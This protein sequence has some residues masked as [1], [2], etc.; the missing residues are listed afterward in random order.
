MRKIFS[1]AMLILWISPC[2]K[3]FAEEGFPCVQDAQNFSSCEEFRAGWESGENAR[4]MGEAVLGTFRR[5]ESSGLKMNA[6]CSPESLLEIDRIRCKLLSIV[7][8][9]KSA[10]AA[11]EE[12]LL[13]VKILERTASVDITGITISERDLIEKATSLPLSNKPLKTEGLKGGTS[14]E[15][16]A[17]FIACAAIS[18]TGS[19]ISFEP[20]ILKRSGRINYINKI[21]PG[22]SFET[23]HAD[24]YRLFLYMRDDTGDSHCCGHTMFFPP[25]ITQLIIP[26]V[27]LLKLQHTDQNSISEINIHQ[28]WRSIFPRPAGTLPGKVGLIT[29]LITGPITLNLRTNEKHIDHLPCSN[30]AEYFTGRGGLSEDHIISNRSIKSYF[31]H[32]HHGGSS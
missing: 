29:P 18:T 16:L 10:G 30:C 26:F 24:Y 11:S 7:E 27:Q 5:A 32:N 19:G 3:V 17:L 20:G 9:G 25:Y 6:L 14:P 2:V 15:D 22:R 23:A 12:I 21:K 28:G 8:S 1:I 13:A 4:I 31:Y